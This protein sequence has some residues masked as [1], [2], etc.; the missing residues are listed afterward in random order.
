MEAYNFLRKKYFIPPDKSLNEFSTPTFADWSGLVKLLEEYSCQIEPFVM[1]K[2][3]EYI[4]GLQVFGYTVRINN[5]NIGDIHNITIEKYE[6]LNK[7]KETFVKKHI[8]YLELRLPSE[9]QKL[10]G[11]FEEL[12][13]NPLIESILRHNGFR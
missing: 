13:L 7:K 3:D 8:D 5:H 1:R 12:L 4:S 6:P 11:R 9:A 10:F 2:I